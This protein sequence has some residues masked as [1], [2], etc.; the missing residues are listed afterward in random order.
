MSH[1][2]GSSYL[3]LQ[4]IGGVENVVPL[5]VDIPRIGG[6]SSDLLFEAVLQE[7]LQF[8]NEYFLI[9][10]LPFGVTVVNFVLKRTAE[11]KS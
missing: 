1:T 9:V 5:N 3:C 11:E 10:V 7:Y 8:L 6:S 4:I 2:K